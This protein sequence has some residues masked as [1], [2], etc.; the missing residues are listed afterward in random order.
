[1]I[2]SQQ[3]SGK[4]SQI[5]KPAMINFLKNLS[6]GVDVKVLVAPLT[7]KINAFNMTGVRSLAVILTKGL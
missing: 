7:Y 1:M 6:L 2:F 3:I 5:N 4:N